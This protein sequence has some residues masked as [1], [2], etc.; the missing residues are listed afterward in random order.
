MCGGGGGGES[1][2][3]PKERTIN[4]FL[5]SNSPISEVVIRL[6]R[7]AEFCRDAK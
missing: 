5:C 7:A 2:Y 3:N 1:L 6:V 4:P